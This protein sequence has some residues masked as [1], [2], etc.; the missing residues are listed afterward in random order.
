MKKCFVAIAMLFAAACAA[1]AGNFTDDYAR[2][3][4]VPAD[5]LL[6][7][8]QVRAEIVKN[9]TQLLGGPKREGRAGDLKLHNS[10]VGFVIAGVRPASGVFMFGGAL[11]EA[12]MLKPEQGGAR[13]YAL[14]GDTAPAI[15]RGNDPLAGLRMLAPVSAEIL[16]DGSDGEAVARI[17]SRDAEWPEFREATTIKT[18]ALK[19][20]VYTDYILKPDSSVLEI[21]YTFMNGGSKGQVLSVASMFLSGD[22][23]N[24]FAPGHGFDMDTTGDKEF[25]LIAA[26]GGGVSYAW[27]PESGTVTIHKGVSRRRIVT[28][29]K[30]KIPAGGEAQFRMF[31]AAGDNGSSGVAELFHERRGDSGFG[32]VTGKALESNSGAP[33][34]DAVITALDG[35]GAPAANADVQDDGSFRLVLPPGEY[36]LQ[37]AAYDRAAPAPVRVSVTAGKT[38]DARISLNPPARLEYS[39][40]DGRGERIPAVVS[41]KKSSPAV[42]E[43]HP[44]FYFNKTHI[45]RAGFFKIHFAMPEPGGVNIRPGTYDVYVSRG[46]EYEIQKLS[47][48]FEPGKTARHDFVLEHSVDTAGHLCGDFHIHSQPS[49]DCD[50]LLADKIRAIAATG[51]EIP[52]ATDHDVNTDYTPYIEQLGMQRYMKSIVG[53]ELTTIRLGHFN[54]YP[55]TYD[56]TKK[57]AGAPV[58]YG[59]SPQD[60]VNAFRDDP[61]GNTLVQ[62]NHPR[63]GSMGYFD[64]IGY[65]PVTGTAQQPDLLTLEFDSME[66]LNGTSYHELDKTLPDWF[67]FLNRGKTMTGLGNSDNHDTFNLGVGYP[68]NCVASPTDAPSEMNEDTFIAA[69][70][71]QQVTVNGGAFIT[72]AANGSAGPGA[73]A[74]AKNGAALRITVQAPKWIKLDSVSLVEGGEIVETR[75]ISAAAGVLRFDETITR[76]PDRD[77]WIVVI[78]Q[79]REALFPVYPGARAYSF[80]NP[81]YLDADGNGRYDPP[82]AFPAASNQ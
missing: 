4:F 19:I 25:P 68:R 60:I 28:F 73:L 43:L 40:K 48:T 61:R 82:L 22:G 18:S 26:V 53:D 32:M 24:L 64:V 3:N 71:G 23:S 36:S 17:T 12:G 10:R 77:T 14:L 29:G 62:I 6:S 41:F 63:S 20:K 55:L 50:D 16:K 67:S 21:R 8:S 69:V 58:W 11:E 51:L 42:D 52:V 57:N 46:L 7:K 38:T 44:D 79:G 27:F 49:N 66:V 31:V 74:N 30:V 56:T 1:H 65:D 34:S 75:D 47:V 35:S 54:A 76:A 81:I 2:G 5:Q 72:V 33:A 70:R 45:Y 15:Y 13:W 37:A 59:M 78:A 39:I 80:T 9:E